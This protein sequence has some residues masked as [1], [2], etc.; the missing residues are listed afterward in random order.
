VL[1]FPDLRPNRQGD[2][3]VSDGHHQSRG[4]SSRRSGCA[5]PHLLAGGLHSQSTAQD[6]GRWGSVRCDRSTSSGRELSERNGGSERQVEAVALG[7]RHRRSRSSWSAC[8]GRKA[9]GRCSARPATMKP[10][11]AHGAFRIDRGRAASVVWSA[12]DLTPADFEVALFSAR[13]NKK[14]ART[15]AARSACLARFPAGQWAPQQG[16][17]GAAGALARCL[18]DRERGSTLAPF[19]LWDSCFP[20]RGWRRFA[21]MGLRS[22]HAWERTSSQLGWWSGLWATLERETEATGWEALGART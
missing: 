22:H 18:L 6:L 19:A 3:P 1:A 4:R 7:C 13:R 5:T 2:P 8:V 17:A 11:A 20:A 16:L 15:L 12:A 10:A 21:A 14:G 9:W